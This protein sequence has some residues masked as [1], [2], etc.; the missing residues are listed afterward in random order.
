[1][2]PFKHLKVKLIV[3]MSRLKA[4]G[5]HFKFFSGSESLVFKAIFS[6]LLCARSNLSR[7]IYFPNAA[8]CNIVIIHNRQ[9]KRLINFIGCIDS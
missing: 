6:A 4:K 8:P 1:M 2:E 9:N 7:S 3:C 5:S